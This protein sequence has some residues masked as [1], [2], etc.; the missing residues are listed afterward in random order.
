M[1]QV[2]LTAAADALS[3]TEPGSFHVTGSS[4]EPDG[5]VDSDI[6]IVPGGSGGFVIALRADRLGSGGGRAYTLTASA[7]DLAGNAVNS[8]AV[9]TVPRDQ[10]H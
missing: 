1:V 5:V 6:E 9:C 2:G 7:N 3:G 8:A 4:N 10:G